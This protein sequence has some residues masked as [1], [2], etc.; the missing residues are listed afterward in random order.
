MAVAATLAAVEGE[1]IPWR[2]AL[3]A[4]LRPLLSYKHEMHLP[5]RALGPKS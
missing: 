4:D 3:A 5:V 2:A 1:R